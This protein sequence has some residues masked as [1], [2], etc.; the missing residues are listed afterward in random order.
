MTQDF[1]TKTPV[2]L[3]ILLGSFLPRGTNP[4]HRQGQYVTTSQ[5]PL[6]NLFA[7]RLNSVIRLQDAR[8]SDYLGVARI[9]VR[10]GNPKDSLQ[11]GWESKLRTRF[12]I[13]DPAL[14][15]INKQTQWLRDV[16]VATS[17]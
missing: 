1:Q 14:F 7:P 4:L 8:S 12:S 15:K 17:D 5:K 2:N 10:A 9:I 16:F 13:T 6:T 11:F 3:G